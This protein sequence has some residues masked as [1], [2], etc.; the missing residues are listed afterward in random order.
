MVF[1]YIRFRLTFYTF[2]QVLVK[3]RFCFAYL[4]I[5]KTC[6]YNLDPLKHHFY[7]VKLGFTGVYI[8]FLI[9]AQKHRL[10]VLVRTASPRRGGSNEY[11]QSMFWAEI[12]KVSEFFYLKM[13][14]FGG[15]I[16]N[17]FEYRRVF[18]MGCNVCAM[19]I[20]LQFAK[21]HIWHKTCLKANYLKS[22]L[23]LLK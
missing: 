18:V 20:H 16:F 17:I 15:E 10:W 4:S 2:S 13:F 12:W 1:N 23:L 3:I 21:R 6:L 5:T 14:M 7:T 9:S 19:C 8:I 22:I 11:P